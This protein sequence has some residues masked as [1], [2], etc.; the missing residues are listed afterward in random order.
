M[1]SNSLNTLDSKLFCA[2]ARQNSHGGG[3]LDKVS[4]INIANKINKKYGKTVIDTSV[5]DINDLWEQIDT[6]I[7][8]KIC[9]GSELCWLNSEYLKDIDLL[10]YY[11]PLIPKGD[12]AWLKTSDINKVLRQFEAEYEEFTFMGSVPIDFDDVIDSYARL[13]TC[14][15]LKRGKTKV[16]FVFNMDNSKQSGSHWVSMFLDIKAGY[17]GFFDSVGKCPPPARIEKLIVR[18]KNQVEKCTGIVLKKKCNKIRHQYD[19]YNCGVYSLYFI[20]QCLMG[21]TFEQ[22]ANAPIGDE[23]IQLYRNFFFRPI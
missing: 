7:D 22:V 20:Y 12:T 15:L 3:C 10:D 23:K 21:K 2:P 5:S 6:K 1:T 17:I 13:D 19:T 8:K 18:I 14:S 16:G 9:S 11:K 4:L